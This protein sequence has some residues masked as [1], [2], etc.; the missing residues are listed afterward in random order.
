[1][2]PYALAG[3]CRKMQGSTGENILQLLEMRLDSVVFRL[4]MAPTM[5]AAR[6][7]VSHGHITVNGRCASVTTVMQHLAA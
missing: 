7:A 3:L 6:Q 5:S 4:G 1:M 2:V